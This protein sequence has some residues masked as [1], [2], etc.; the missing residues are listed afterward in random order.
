MIAGVLAHRRA[1]VSASI[2]AAGALAL[3]ALTRVHVPVLG[4][5]RLL[6]V[7]IV[8]LALGSGPIWGSFAGA[9]AG[10]LYEAGE[11][12]DERL[13]AVGSIG[14]L[15]RLAGFVAIG[16]VVGSSAARDRELSGRAERDFLTDLLNADALEAALARRLASGRAFMLIL[17]DLEGLHH[18]NEA[19][20]HAAGNDRLR[21]FAAVLREETAPGDTV[22]RI[23]GDEFA[24][25]KAVGSQPEAENVCDR[26]RA[27]LAA[28]GMG[29]SFGYAM[30]PDEGD[31]R[32]SLFH[33][34]DKRLYA[35]KH[36]LGER[37][38]FAVS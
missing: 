24:V 29:A 31:D 21:R 20:G 18:V 16:W 35:A 23:G 13:A 26:L 32:L 6:Y 30:C 9:V 12:V 14:A 34:A 25:L 36:G 2:A 1:F 27:A 33:G 11:L 37:R 15:I 10:G 8:L 3:V 38:L 4:L 19:K 22:A 28:R 5:D 17:A 7:P